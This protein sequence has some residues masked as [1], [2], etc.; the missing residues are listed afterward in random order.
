[1]DK[2]QSFC[3][4]HKRSGGSTVSVTKRFTVCLLWHYI[5][6]PI[7]MDGVEQSRQLMFS[8]GRFCCICLTEQNKEILTDIGKL[9]TTTLTTVLIYVFSDFHPSKIHTSYV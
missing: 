4:S 6:M 8:R 5:A 3:T 7:G 9:E 2:S 1:M